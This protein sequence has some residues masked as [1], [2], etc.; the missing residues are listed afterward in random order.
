MS[1]LQFKFYNQAQGEL[2]PSF[3]GEKIPETHHVRLLS[4]IVDALDITDLLETY[5]SFG[6]PAYHPRM[7]LKVVFY[8]YMNNIFSCRKIEKALL[9]DIHFIWLAGCNKPDYITVN[10]FRNRVKGEINNVFTQLVLILA[11]KGFVSLDVKYIDGTKIE[12]KTNKYTFVWRMT[13]D[14][15]RAK[16]ME[17]IK[18]L[19]S[20]V[21]KAIAQDNADE[22]SAV[23][24]TPEMLDNICDYCSFQ[25]IVLAIILVE[26]AEVN[27]QRFQLLLRKVH[28]FK[29]FQ[30]FFLARLAHREAV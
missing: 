9:R 25:S 6:C 18:V 17:K 13:V 22:G 16:L 8:A 29:E 15:N 23:E 12:S 7:L 19:L 27:C 5:R 11:E 26:W 24:F 20:Q 10:R 21:D 2:F 14:R 28:I 4:G 30:K 3:L 1:K